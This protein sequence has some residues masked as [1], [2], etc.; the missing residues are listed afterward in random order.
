MLPLK[1]LL[2]PSTPFEEIGGVSTHVHMLAGGLHELGHDVHVTAWLPPRPYRA[3]FVTLPALALGTFSGYLSYRWALAAKHLYYL[4]DGLIASSFRPDIVNIQNVQHITM[5]RRMRAMTGCGVVLT[6]HGF[7]T[8]EAEQSG[9][10]VQGDKFWHWLRRREAAGY[11]DADNIVAVSS[12]IAAYV[13]EGFEHAPVTVIHNGIDTRVFSPRNS[14][15]DSSRPPGLRLLF[16]GCLEP[17][18]GLVDA[19]EAL[20]ILRHG[21]AAARLAVAGDGRERERARSLAAELS[22]DS[23][24]D[25]RGTLAKSAMPSFYASGDVLLM[26]SK[27]RGSGGVE[28]SFPYTALEAMACGIPVIAYHTGG[29]PELIKDGHTGILVPAGDN[30]A[31][32]AAAM[33]F[34]DDALQRRMGLNARRHV[35]E[36]FSASDMASRF[37]AVYRKT[38]GQA[39]GR[40]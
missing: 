29:L 24:I 22:V 23:A 36:R 25:W 19:I 32:A 11:P 7:L 16:A 35:E 1:I 20:A 17:H 3:P 10:C 8:D 37:V 21:G 4:I 34:T 39:K 9:R 28:E 2:V 14:Q 27:P 26:P 6:M 38:A 13:T 12:S 31:L 33:L 15:V 18:K 5:A 30:R 40:R